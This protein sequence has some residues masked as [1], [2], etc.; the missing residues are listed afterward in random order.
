MF[1]LCQHIA[2]D[3]Q[4]SRAKLSK[5]ETSCINS[6]KKVSEWKFTQVNNC[7]HCSAICSNNKQAELSL[8]LG[9]GL[10]LASV[11]CD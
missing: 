6:R 11:W 1:N 8:K 2:L 10:G 3:T 4:Q 9:K 5:L 7:C